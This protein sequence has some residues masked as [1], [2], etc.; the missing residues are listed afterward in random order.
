MLRGRIGNRRYPILAAAADDLYFN[1]NEEIPYPDADMQ[2]S[3]ED[4]E[5]EE[6]DEDECVEN[7]VLGG[8]LRD[9]FSYRHMR[10]DHLP[11]EEYQ[12]PE[13]SEDVLPF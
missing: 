7:W 11:N 6:D 12:P 4:G 5:T 13:D 10:R 1:T 8:L 2:E 3:D 9:R